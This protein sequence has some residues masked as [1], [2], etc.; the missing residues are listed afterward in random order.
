MPRRQ[1]PPRGGARPTSALGCG[2]RPLEEQHLGDAPDRGPRRRRHRPRGRRRGAEGPRPARGARGVRHRAGRVRPRRSP[3]PRHRGGARRRDARGAARFDAI[4]L[5]AVGTPEVPPGIIERGLLLKLRF[6]FDQY[7]NLRP[8][9]LYPGVVSPVAGLTPERCDFVVVRENTES[10]YAGAGG[11]L[12]RGTP[13]EVATQESVNTRHGVERVLRF[14]FEQAQRRDGKLTLVHKT[15]V[16]VHAGDLWMRTFEEVGRRRLPG[17]RAR[18]RPRRRGLPVLRHA[19]GTLRRGGHREPL[20]RHHHR[21]RRGGAGRD[22]ARSVRQPRSDPPGSVDVR[23]GPR[24]GARH[25]RDRQ[26]RPDRRGDEP[27][28]AARLPR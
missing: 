2:D 1:H 11:A 25:R 15:N 24:L 4:Y 3:L 5:G 23:A 13:H 20:R 18:L 26:G 12:Y 16:L 19:A 10:V 21:P 6:A 28:P 7:V 8:V 14:A 27:R 9:K 17:R 22:G